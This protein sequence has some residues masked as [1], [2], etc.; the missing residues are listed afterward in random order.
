MFGATAS[1]VSARVLAVVCS[2]LL[3]AVTVAD[4]RADD[5]WF[6]GILGKTW[7]NNAGW[8]ESS[9]WYCY[10][11][12]WVGTYGSGDLRVRLWTDKWDVRTHSVFEWP[13]YPA[14]NW[15]WFYSGASLASGSS[16]AE[17]DRY[18]AR[19]TRGASD[20]YYFDANLQG[21]VYVGSTSD[22]FGDSAHPYDYTAYTP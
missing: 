7:R 2:I 20:H 11:G 10:G 9:E 5:R 1:K 17:T 3:A 4:A 8:Y 12:A 18:H 16:S 13:P 21:Y 14:W 19:C 22:G 6:G 15:E